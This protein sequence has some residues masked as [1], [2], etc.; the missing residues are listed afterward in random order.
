MSNVKI[1][2]IDD[3][4]EILFAISAICEYQGW[5]PLTASSVQEGVEKFKE[6]KPDIVLIDYHLP[7]TNGIQ[8]VKMLKKISNNIP[9][10][11]LTI[12]ENEKVAYEFMKAGAS[13]FALKPIKALDIIARINVHLR[14]KETIENVNKNINDYSK[15]ISIETLEKI[16]NYMSG[17][18]G[19][20]SINNISKNTGLAYQTV[21]RY[22]Q[23]MIEKGKVE[24]NQS[25]GKIGRPKQSYKFIK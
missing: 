23:Y 13:D 8:G 18:S 2:V 3:D 17:L 16:Q 25:Y 6:I 15:G 5:I 19:Y 7:K 1:L 21:H 22:L 11:V 14:L 10:I 12:E 9:I 24:V 20:I 4:K